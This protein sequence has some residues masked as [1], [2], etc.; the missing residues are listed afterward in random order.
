MTSRFGF[1]TYKLIVSLIDFTFTSKSRRPFGRPIADTVKPERSHF[2]LS[3]LN[4]APAG[5]SDSL[6]LA[7]LPRLQVTAK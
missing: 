1:E 7:I 5:F 3:P 6:A 2:L 4:P